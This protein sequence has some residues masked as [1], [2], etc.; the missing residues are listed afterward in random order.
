MIEVEYQKLLAKEV[1]DLK[2][3]AL[4]DEEI[5]RSEKAIV[6]KWGKFSGRSG[7]YTKY[8]KK[9][10]TPKNFIRKF[11]V[12]KRLTRLKFLEKKCFKLNP[13][14]LKSYRGLVF[15]GRC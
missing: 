9:K 5:L 15:W 2:Q 12:L 11:N 1:E 13:T 6:E 14:F 10:M 8:N 3:I 4:L 7:E